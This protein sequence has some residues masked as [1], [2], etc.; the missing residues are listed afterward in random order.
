MA[1]LS[2]EEKAAVTA[3]WNKVDVED[4]GGEALRRLLIV[5]TWTRRSFMTFGDLS[6]PSAILANPKV[7]IH[8]KKVLGAF[9]KSLNHLDNLNDTFAQLSEL[10]CDKLHVEPEN[11]MRLGN[12]LMLVL[13]RHFGKDV[14]PQMQAALQKLFAGVAMAMAH[15]YH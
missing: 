2:P 9:T 10:H 1:L 4:V 11:F 15:K 13:A 8:G 7:T 3:L 14:T 5:Y 6:S 12:M